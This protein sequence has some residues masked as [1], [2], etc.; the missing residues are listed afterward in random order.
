MELQDLSSLE[1]V[2]LRYLA[3]RNPKMTLILKVQDQILTS[4]REFLRNEGF[5][6]ILAPIIGPPEATA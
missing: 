6:E 1:S 3:I 4:L 5:I 2:R